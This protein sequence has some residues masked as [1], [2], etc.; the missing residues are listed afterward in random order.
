[1]VAMPHKPDPVRMTESEYLAFEHESDAKHEFINGYVYA[2]AGAKREHS[3]ITGN[4]FASCH[5]QFQGRGCEVHQ[6]E[7]RVKVSA[8]KYFYPDITII[9]GEPILADDEFD[10]LLNPTVIVEVLSPS[11]EA[12]DR[13]DKF[14]YY[15]SIES[16]QEY[17]LVS[18]EKA[19]IE[20][21]VRQDSGLW[22]FSAAIGL[23]AIFKLSSISCAFNLSKIYD[24]ITLESENDPS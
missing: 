11:T 6:S 14:Q 1:M 19:R 23:D 2:M 12:F 16:L 4:I 22:T 24:R 13:G 20:G 3:L 10:N 18:Q 17:I 21:F 9:C 8:S 5:S 7:L 15:R